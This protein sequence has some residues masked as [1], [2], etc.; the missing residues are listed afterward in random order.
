[1][2]TA[3]YTAT[4]T[5]LSGALT[6]NVGGDITQLE[7]EELTTA[8]H[9]VRPYSNAIRGNVPVNLTTVAT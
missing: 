1:M 4:A 9:Q 7:A 8:A 6:V 3:L 2:T 5:S